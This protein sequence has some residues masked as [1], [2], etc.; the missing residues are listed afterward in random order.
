MKETSKES[1]IIAYYN[2]KRGGDG[3]DNLNVFQMPKGHNLYISGS[4]RVINGQN[5]DDGVNAIV[6]RVDVE[7]NKIT[8]VSYKKQGLKE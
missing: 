8:A 2:I 1:K 6:T 7:T 3:K 5:F 4:I